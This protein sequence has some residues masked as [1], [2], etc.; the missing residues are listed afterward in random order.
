[1]VDKQARQGRQEKPNMILLPTGL[2]TQRQPLAETQSRREKRNPLLTGMKGIKG[3]FP[4][5][6]ESIKGSF[7]PFPSTRSGQATGSGQAKPRDA[8]KNIDLDL[9]FLILI[10]FAGFACP[11]QAKRVEG[12][13]LRETDF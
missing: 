12:R 3:M 11:E 10:L 4:V 7:S 1:M 13:S 5:C 2:T 6:C 9:T 8:R